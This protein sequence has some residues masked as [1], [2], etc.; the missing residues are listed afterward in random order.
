MG[1]PTKIEGFAIVSQDGMLA[2]SHGVMPDTLK[3]EAD[4]RFFRE[5][6]DRCVA[7]VHG[8][9]SHEQQPNSGKR[10][11]LWVTA[12]VKGIEVEDVT[13][14]SV[15]W[16]PDGA[17]FEQAWDALGVE[18]AL[19]V[20]GG[21]MVFGLFL[22]LYDVFHLTRAPAVKLPGG[23][24]VFPGVPA[25]SPEDIMKKAGLREGKTR[26]LDARHNLTVTEWRRK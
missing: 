3:F 18:G 5:G 14:K 1:G 9:H 19:G 26:V 12:R 13:P 2:D 21:T 24:P 7:A 6:L 10:A 11:R 17:A 20:V 22:P 23:R 8:R 25:R 15:L 16:N 4:Q